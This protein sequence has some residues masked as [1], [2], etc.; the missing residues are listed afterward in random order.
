MNIL[1]LTDDML[2]GG[3][4]RHVADIANALSAESNSI[5][6][7][8]TD[9]EARKWLSKDIKFIPIFL[10]NN[11]QQTNNYFGF[12]PSYR[13]LYSLLKQKKFDLVHSHKRYSHL[14]GK[15]VAQQFHIPYITSYHTVF[16][17]KKYFS[18]FGDKTICCSRAVKE[19]MLKVYG[20]SNDELITIPNGINPFREYSQL[21]KENVKKELNIPISHTII[22]SVGQFV[23]EKD[24]VTL[25]YALNE[26]RKRNGFFNVSVLLQGYGPQ[27]QL[28]QNLTKSFSLENVVNFVDGNYSVEAICNISDFMILNSV[29]E[30][31]GLVLLEAASVGKAHIASNIG[32]IPEFVEHQST[33]IL[34]SPKNVFELADAVELLINNKSLQFE[35]GINAK[36]KYERSFTFGKMYHEIKNVYAKVIAVSH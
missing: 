25:L 27:K 31:F 26:L 22:G 8:A 18:F 2:I 10:K 1:L 11:N 13:K 15:I 6:V 35:L 7:A 24:R 29:T 28:L 4:T 21:E 36:R 33:G 9:G 3:V 19:V 34:I 23:P 5:T 30:G 16:S 32:G 12:V 20:R 14:L 17:D